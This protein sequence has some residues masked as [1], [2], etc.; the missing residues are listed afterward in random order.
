[1]SSLFD[2][3]FLADLT[4]SD[5]VPPPPEDH[6]APRSRARTISSG[7]QFDVPMSGDAY[8]RDGA[9]RPVIDPA[10]LLDGL[11]ERAARG[12]RARGRARCSSWPA[13]ARARP[14]C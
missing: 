14:G 2:D 5:E 9:P 10:T 7:A 12:R 1:M 4:P 11:N 13:P 8:Y 6:A 3:S